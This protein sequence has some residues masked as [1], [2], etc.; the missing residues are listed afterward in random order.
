METQIPI[1]RKDDPNQW[2][3]LPVTQAIWVE[4]VADKFGIRNIEFQLGNILTHIIGDDANCFGV[5]SN[6]YI[7]E[8][9]L[10]GKEDLLIRMRWEAGHPQTPEEIRR[11]LEIIIPYAEAA[12]WGR[13]KDF[14][15][16]Q[17]AWTR[18]IKAAT[19]REI[20]LH[21]EYDETMRY[22]QECERIISKPFA[23]FL[24]SQ[25]AGIA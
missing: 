6:I 1:P 10:I 7:R 2:G 18:E 22:R 3:K 20:E 11:R 4:S 24:D 16:V 9:A 17:D 15:D 23:D 12:N 25:T 8:H 5:A 19:E 14:R 13:E 21:P